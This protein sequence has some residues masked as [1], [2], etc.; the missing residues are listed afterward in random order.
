[1]DPEVNQKVVQVVGKTL[2]NHIK[3]NGNT[4]MSQVEAEELREKVR[5]LERNVCRKTWQTR[6]AIILSL[7]ST[8]WAHR[9]TIDLALNAVFQFC[10]TTFTIAAGA[11][12]KKIK[13]KRH[14]KGVR[15]G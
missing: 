3:R 14:G 11:A 1:V 15:L 4:V 8:Y 13:H 12:I 2:K 10:V 7:G 9:A 5:Q 6:A